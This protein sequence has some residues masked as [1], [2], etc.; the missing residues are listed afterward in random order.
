LDLAGE[1]QSEF[2]RYLDPRGQ[3]GV[4]DRFFLQI[5]MSAPTRVERVDL[6]RGADGAYGDFPNH[7]ALNNFDPADRKF[8]AL[9]RRTGAPVANATDSDWLHHRATLAKHGVNVQFVCG[10]DIQGWFAS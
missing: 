2:R 8:A 7:P 4:G 9:A 5:L 10:C 1:I 6:P 3:P